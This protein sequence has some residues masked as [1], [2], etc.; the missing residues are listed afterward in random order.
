MSS[1]SPVN[2]FLPCRKGS[3]RVPRKNIKPFAGFANGLIE[4]K[5]RQLIGAKGI[6]KIYL[7][8]NDEEIL[9]YAATLGSD[10]IVLHKRCEELSSSQT[11]T[12][13]LVA[14][15]LELIGDG[16]IMWTHVTSPFVSA[17]S[18]DSI[19]ARYR[20]ALDEGHD[21]LMTTSVIHGFIWNEDGPVNYD[22][23]IE[24]WP[25]TQTLPTL[26]EINSAAF[27]APA[28]IYRDEDDRIG[29]NP[30]IYGMDKIEGMDIDW[31]VDFQIAESMVLQGIASV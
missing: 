3:E 18:Y 7:S 8:T 12:D 21:S 11:S 29:R 25:R 1:T 9:D 31:P 10:K 30:F 4:V 15:A 14:H 16:D 23:N 19:V 2:C 27:L 13:D 28:S 24:K 20:E 26:Y 22:R 17:A 5:L 6:G